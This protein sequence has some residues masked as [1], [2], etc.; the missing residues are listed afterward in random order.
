[1]AYRDGR[2]F[3]GKFL[4]LRKTSPD[5]VV[6]HKLWGGLLRRQRWGQSG[7]SHSCPVT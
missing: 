4:D 7:R 2:L 1:M 6:T 5:L 3:R